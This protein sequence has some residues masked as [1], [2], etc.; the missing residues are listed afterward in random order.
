M[1]EQPTLLFYPI[2]AHENHLGLAGQG[3]LPI[4]HHVIF[5][6]YPVPIELRCEAPLS[7]MCVRQLGRNMVSCG[8]HSEGGVVRIRASAI[9]DLLNV[10]R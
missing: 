10:N 6:T 2:G 5:F 3:G 7:E 9:V 8:T 1:R 4:F